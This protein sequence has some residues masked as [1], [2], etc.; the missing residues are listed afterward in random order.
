MIS[1]ED[2]SIQQEPNIPHRHFY[3]NP[4]LSYVCFKTV[5]LHN[6]Y[7]QLGLQL[8]HFISLRVTGGWKPVLAAFRQEAG[9]NL[10]KLPALCRSNI[11]SRNKPFTLTFT[12]KGQFNDAVSPVSQMYVFGLEDED[13]APRDSPPGYGKSVQTPHRAK[14]QTIATSIILKLRLNKVHN[15]HCM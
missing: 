7:Q 4:R 10:D 3:C 1:V 5:M 9:Y 13:E 8:T 15:R 14:H 12:P 6:L 11:Y 2:F